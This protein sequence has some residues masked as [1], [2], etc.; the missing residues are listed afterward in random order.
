MSNL[1]YRLLPGG[2]RLEGTDAWQRH[3]VL[4]RSL[5][6]QLLPDPKAAGDFTRR[7]HRGDL[8]GFE[9]WLTRAGLAT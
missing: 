9:E 8:L 7:F 6:A 3:E 5:E 2:Q 1:A 4:L